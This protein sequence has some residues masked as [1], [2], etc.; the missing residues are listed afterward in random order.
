MVSVGD[1]VV[2]GFGDEVGGVADGFVSVV[3]LG[4]LIEPGL[5]VVLPVEG[6]LPLPLMLPLFMLP[7][8]FV[9]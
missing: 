9:P 1:G 7:L 5:V 8:S 2:D 4:L 6:E 3:P